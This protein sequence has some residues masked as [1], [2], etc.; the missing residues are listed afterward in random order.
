MAILGL[1]ISIVD[2]FKL[3]L[4]RFNGLEIGSVFSLSGC[5]TFGVVAAMAVVSVMAVGAASF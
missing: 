2:C 3:I 5:V 1:L 4:A